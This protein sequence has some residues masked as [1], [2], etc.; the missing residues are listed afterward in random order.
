M[1]NRYASNNQ[2]AILRSI[3]QVFLVH[4]INGGL[5]YAWKTTNRGTWSPNQTQENAAT[6]QYFIA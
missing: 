4:Q 2:V 6:L 1:D 5:T 3:F